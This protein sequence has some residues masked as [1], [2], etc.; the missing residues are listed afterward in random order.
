MET[1]A[2]PSDPAL[3]ALADT[4]GAVRRMSWLAVAGLVFWTLVLVVLALMLAQVGVEGNRL[5]AGAAAFYWSILGVPVLLHIWPIAALRRAAKAL[6]AFAA[7]PSEAAAAGALGAQRLYW[8]AAG[9]C[10]L[11]I[12]L[13]FLLLAAVWLAT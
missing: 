6:A 12:V 13:W 2:I 5:P 8:R 7:R 3:G 10:H 4:E 1:P 9:I 11:I